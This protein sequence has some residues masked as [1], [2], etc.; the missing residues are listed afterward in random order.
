MVRGKELH[1]TGDGLIKVWKIFYTVFS[2]WSN[3]RYLRIIKI[4]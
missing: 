4:N 2:R 3:C 1:S